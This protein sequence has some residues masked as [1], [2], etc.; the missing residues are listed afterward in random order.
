M[1]LAKAI[2]VEQNEDG[3]HELSWTSAFSAA[4]VDIYGGQSPDTIDM[5]NALAVDV[6]R[7]T[8]IAGLVPNIRHYFRLCRHGQAPVMVAQRNVP[9]AGCV[10]FRDLGG[11]LAEDG[12]RVKWG[13][14]FRSGHM[15]NLTPG[16]RDYFAKLD[17]KA[18]CDFRISEER[19]SEATDLPN[20]PSMNIL[21][22]PPGIKDRFF[23]HRVFQDAS[24][25]ED[26]VKAVHEIVLSMVNESAARYQRLFDVLLEC[27]DENILINCSAGKERTGV[28]SALI[29]TALGVPRAT[30][31][32]DFMLSKQYFPTQKEIPRVLKKYNVGEGLA[33]QQL[34]MPLLETHESYLRTAFESI[35][36]NFGD[37][38]GF[39]KQR[40]G[41]GPNELNELR[42]RYTS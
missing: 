4:P 25:P 20:N 23:L 18:V 34:I 6:T 12:R 27:T 30:I 37:G 33:A 42:D 3:T 15:S 35:D 14:L 9:L 32:Y 21:E 40:Y 29:L 36:K 22:I 28:A 7:S 19:A 26:V 38:L 8:T 17:I 5:G 1:Q 31:Y 24:G 10:N 13:R 11:Y 39:L 16:A 2:Q 41:I